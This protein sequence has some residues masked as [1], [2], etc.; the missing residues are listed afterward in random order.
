MSIAPSSL[1]ASA[2]TRREQEREKEIE[3]DR[4][5]MWVKEKKSWAL[6]QQVSV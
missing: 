5:T 2:H 3:R 1:N 4:E 6:G